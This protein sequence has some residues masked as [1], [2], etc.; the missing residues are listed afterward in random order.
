MSVAQ[1]ISAYSRS[2]AAAAGV[3][4]ITGTLL[5]GCKTTKR[6]ADPTVTGS[7]TAANP[8]IKRTQELARHWEKDT[9]NIDAALSYSASL[10]AIGSQAQA[11]NVLRQ[12]AIKNPGDQRMMI[13]LGKE[14][15][16]AGQLE[17]AD[18][19]LQKAIATGPVTWQLQSTMGTVLDRMGRHEQAQDHYVRALKLSP[20]NTA[21]TN[22]LAMSH[23]LAGKPDEAEKMLRAALPKAQDKPAGQMR[24]NLALVLGLQGKFDQAR[25]VLSQELPPH[26]VDA[27]MAYIRNMISQPNRWKQIQQSDAPKSSRKKKS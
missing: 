5:T 21:I 18:K 8:M 4:L 17:E 15:A 2:V 13:A 23:A 11:V 26:K 6:D 7:V 9:S 19:V 3:I 22:N 12:T 16:A 14:L 27:N 25:D 20:G 1:R 24:Q 10:K